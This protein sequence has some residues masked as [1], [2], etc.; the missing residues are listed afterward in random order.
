MNRNIGL[1][2]LMLIFGIPVSAQ[3]GEHRSDFAIGFNGGYMMS[4]VGFTPEVQQKQHGGL[5]GGFSMRYTCEKYFK[6]ICSI[7]AEVNYSQAG[8]EEDILDMENNPV[9]ITE[10]KEAMAYKRTINY[11]Q[12]P[13]FAH[14]RSDKP[15]KSL[16]FFLHHLR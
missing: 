11:I 9:I 16:C 12:V 8:W 3:I 2:I 4:S 15:G 6:T 13:I 1:L 10:T 14:H 7:Y 5:T